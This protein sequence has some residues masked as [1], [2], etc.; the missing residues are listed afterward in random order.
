ASLSG[1]TNIP[2]VGTASITVGSTTKS[3]NWGAGDDAI[4]IA[5]NL[6]SQL[7][8]DPNAAADATWS[9]GVVTLYARIPGAM[10][11]TGGISHTATS[12]FPNSSISVSPSSG[13]PLPGG[14]NA[15]T[16]LYSYTLGFANDGN[17]TSANDS[18]NGNWT[19]TYDQFNRLLTSNKNSGQQAFSYGYDRFGN[20]WTQTVTAGSGPQPSYSFTG[21]NNRIDGYSYDAT[22]NLL[23]DGTHNYVYDAE[24]RIACMDP[25]TAGA[26]ANGAA[27]TYVYDAEGRRV[28]G[29]TNDY[30]YDLA[31]HAITLIGISNGG[32]N[33]GE[34]YAAGRHIATCSHS[35]T[36]FNHI[37]WLGTERAR[38]NIS[39]SSVET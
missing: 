11:Y 31:G 9:G 17:I 12:N 23:N 15:V 13:T 18:V 8:N 39:A 19:Y 33:V 2:D 27:A 38:S 22:G 36:V 34:V 37:D 35:T 5:T 30:L 28:R 21:G 3:Y 14:N 20:R 32:W 7:H 16:P 29:Q 25:V 1:G 24:N 6:G 4:S 10:S 26:C